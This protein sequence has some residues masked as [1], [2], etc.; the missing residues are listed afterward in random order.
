LQFTESIRNW[1]YV[2][3]APLQLTEDPHAVYQEVEDGVELQ[4][5]SVGLMDYNPWEYPGSQ[6]EG[7][8]ILRTVSDH[9]GLATVALEDPVYQHQSVESPGVFS[10][11]LPYLCHIKP[12]K[13]CRAGEKNDPN[14]LLALSWTLHNRFDGLHMQQGCPTLI[15]HPLNS[16]ESQ[17]EGRRRLN[18]RLVFRFGKPDTIILKDGAVFGG[19]FQNADRMQ[20]YDTFIETQDVEKTTE[21]LNHKKETTLAL[22]G[23]MHWV[24]PPGLS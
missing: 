3:N 5:A 21:Y 7:R 22:W 20:Y 6:G 23:D 19:C 14:N 16:V 4:L 8:T 1:N 10:E 24:I 2:H 9:T 11:E 13:E 15:I 17:V 12:K 18:I